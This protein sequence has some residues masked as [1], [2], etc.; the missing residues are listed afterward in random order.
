MV[1]F[2]VCVEYLSTGKSPLE[3]RSGIIE[4]IWF[5]LTYVIRKQ[6]GWIQTNLICY[7]LWK[8]SWQNNFIKF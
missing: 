8:L 2:F 1:V 3:I 4:R 7:E 6:V 5:I